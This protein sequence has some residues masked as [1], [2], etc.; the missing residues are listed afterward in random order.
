VQSWTHRVAHSHNPNLYKE[1]SSTPD[2]NIAVTIIFLWMISQFFFEALYPSLKA[3]CELSLNPYLFHKRRTQAL[4]Q[5]R[6]HSPCIPA[7]QMPQRAKAKGIAII[8]IKCRSRLI[9]PP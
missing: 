7:N 3:R 8:S 4:F 9:I 5:S 6:L 2:N 1:A